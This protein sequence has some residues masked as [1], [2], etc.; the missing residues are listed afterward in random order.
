MSKEM[1]LA[2]AKAEQVT[3]AL[4]NLKLRERLRNQSIRDP[5]TA[6]FNRRYLEE[7]LE[8]ELR[9]SVRHGRPLTVIMLDLDHFKTFNDSFGHA[10]GDAV[11]QASG[12]LLQTFLRKEDIACRFGGEELAIVLS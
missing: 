10:A 9:R 8:R 4:A 6:L 1:R 2:T 11:L 12:D 5:L 3:L 7:T